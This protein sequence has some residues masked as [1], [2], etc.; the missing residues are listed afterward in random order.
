[1]TGWMVHVLESGIT[2]T[3]ISNHTG[4]VSMKKV[5]VKNSEYVMSIDCT[6]MKPL[7]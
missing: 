1:M 4:L 6:R 3:P 2:K 5:R 7:E